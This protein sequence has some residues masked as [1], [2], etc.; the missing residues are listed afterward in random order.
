[1]DKFDL[2]FRCDNCN[3]GFGYGW[4]FFNTTFPLPNIGDTLFLSGNKY[5]EADGKYIVKRRHFNYKIE[6]EEGL[7]SCEVLIEVEPCE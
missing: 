2:V 4:F 7:C 6:K 5:P 3:D 1:M